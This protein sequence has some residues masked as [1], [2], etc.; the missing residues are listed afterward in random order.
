MS[1]PDDR[2]LP[3][4]P[5]AEE[6]VDIW[7]VEKSEALTREGADPADPRWDKIGGE[8]TIEEFDDA[9]RE[10]DACSDADSDE[11]P[12]GPFTRMIP[13]LPL[14]AVLA[15]LAMVATYVIR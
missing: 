5:W 9:E 7:A 1:A 14:I 11:C 8:P 12:D 10:L 2:D 13:W 4:D 6:G 3:P 15:V